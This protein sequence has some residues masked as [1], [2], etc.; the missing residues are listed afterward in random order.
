MIDALVGSDYSDCL[1]SALKDAGTD[2][3][4]I[5]PAN[6]RTNPSINFPI[7]K[8]SPSKDKNI[9]KFN[10]T[11]RYLNYLFKVLKFI[12]Q[13]RINVVHYQFFRR[14]SETFFF[15]LLKLLKVKLV[16][17]AHNVMPHENSR[18]DFKIQSLVINSST[19]IIAH[20]NFIK[21]KLIETF[22]IEKD[23]IRVISHGNYDSQLPE[24]LMSKKQARNDLKITQDKDLILFFGAIKQYKGLDLLLD[25]FEIAS[26]DNKN[27][28]LVIA[29]SLDSEQLK[30]KYVYKIN[31]L[32]SKNNIIQNFTYIPTEKVAN[33]FIAADIIALPYKNIYHSGII[34]L[35][36]SFGR[37]FIATDVGD[38]KEMSDAGKC[39]KISPENTAASFAETI[40]D[41]FVN[42][43]RLEAMGKYCKKTSETKYSWNDIAIK[44]RDL[45]KDIL[46][47]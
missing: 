32:K 25:A 11:F 30:N 33:Y 5:V 29:G 17:T 43:T 8:W 23:K 42:K 21:I 18:H 38:F 44:T 10:K 45:Y 6:K 28:K 4:L 16:Y 2:I 36:F 20:T 46:S 35:A 37:P 27:L 31:Q 14:K 7:L 40:L 12:H 47:R 1:C 24:K 39:G 13:N 3:T 41:C 19:A 15:Y 26:Q 22:N 9:G 34:H